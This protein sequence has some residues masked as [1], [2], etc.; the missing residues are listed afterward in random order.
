MTVTAPVAHYSYLLKCQV[1]SVGLCNVFL[2]T[3]GQAEVGQYLLPNVRSVWN[4]V[5]RFSVLMLPG[6]WQ[7]NFRT[8]N[9]LAKQAG[10]Q[11]AL[12][13]GA[14]FFHSK[15]NQSTI[16]LCHCII[17]FSLLSYNW[18]HPEIVSQALHDY[19][20]SL[21]LFRL[22]FFMRIVFYF[23]VPGHTAHRNH[24]MNTG[25]W[26]ISCSYYVAKVMSFGLWNSVGRK[27][28]PLGK[29]GSKSLYLIHCTFY[30]HL[31]LVLL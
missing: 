14:K 13:G 29:E 27:D 8:V 12:L 9:K 7:S 19:M 30:S 28:P 18:L 15:N 25:G 31:L 16:P 22:E 5:R 26:Y 4:S 24:V 21:G 6:Y 1:A 20:L 11:P 23:L 10:L 2:C 3:W 17:A